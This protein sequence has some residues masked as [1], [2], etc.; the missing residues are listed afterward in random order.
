MADSIENFIETIC[1]RLGVKYGG[2]YT[3]SSGRLDG[4]P[5]SEIAFHVG[6]NRHDRIQP[7][8]GEVFQ[9]TGV[10]YKALV[11]AKRTI[12]KNQHGTFVAKFEDLKNAQMFT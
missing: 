11:G 3:I 10:V 1:A 4:E 6:D 12:V 5:R 8:T 2:Y 9:G 7:A